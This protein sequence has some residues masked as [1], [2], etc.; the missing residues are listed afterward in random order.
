MHSGILALWNAL[1]CSAWN[2]VPKKHSSQLQSL[3]CTVH[4]QPCVSL[5]SILSST[6][7]RLLWHYP[8]STGF[9]SKTDRGPNPCLGFHATMPTACQVVSLPVGETAPWTSGHI[10][11]NPDGLQPVSSFVWLSF[12]GGGLGNF[13]A[14]G[15]LA[16]VLVVPPMRCLAFAPIVEIWKNAQQWGIAKVLNKSPLQPS[17]TM[18]RSLQSCQSVPSTTTIVVASKAGRCVNALFTAT[19]IGWLANLWL[20]NSRLHQSSHQPGA[21]FS[22]SK[23]VDENLS[24]PSSTNTDAD[25]W[26]GVASLRVGSGRMTATSGL[27]QVKPWDAVCLSCTW[28]KVTLPLVLPNVCRVSRGGS[29][30]LTRTFSLLF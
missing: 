12:E 18:R 19:Q 7:W 8:D 15:R 17:P 10:R 4:K 14:R 24:K 3:T 23:S 20:C 16:L 2:Q 13:R 11:P 25:R 26:G 29:I 21:I 1:C 30:Y 22:C 5:W 28:G 6:L 27:T 9:Q